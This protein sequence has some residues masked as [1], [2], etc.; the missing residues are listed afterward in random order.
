M[1]KIQFTLHH[2][3]L[4]HIHSC[5]TILMVFCIKKTINLFFRLKS[6]VKLLGKILLILLPLELVEN[7]LKIVKLFGY[8]VDSILSKLPPVLWLKGSSP[9][10]SN[11]WL[12]LIGFKVLS[13]TLISSKLFLWLIQMESFTETLGLK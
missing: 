10:C 5:F 4:I 1:L 7:L 2:L 3:I 6:C 9:I 12:K 8:L 13:M 11:L